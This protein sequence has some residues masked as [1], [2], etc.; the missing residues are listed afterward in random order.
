MVR[1]FFFLIVFIPIQIVSQ[2]TVKGCYVNNFAIIGWFGT[3]IQFNED[4]TFNYLF[5]GDLYHDRIDGVY[6]IKNDTI[7]LEY[8]ERTD[9]TYLEIREPDGV[10]RIP[11]IRPKNQA[12]GYRP[13]KLLIKKGKLLIYREEDQ[14]I[15]Y[16]YNANHRRQRYFL[17]SSEENCFDQ[18]RKE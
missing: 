5:A 15:R 12:S 2:T 11:I 10:K 6:S 14:F 9:T 13:V 1:F 16:Q 8:I 3:Q 4:S 7:Y 18:E 17:I